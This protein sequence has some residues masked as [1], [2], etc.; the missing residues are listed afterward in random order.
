MCQVEGVEVT[1]VPFRENANALV[2]SVFACKVL[3][4]VFHLLIT[5]TPRITISRVAAS[6]MHGGIA[7]L[8]NRL[9]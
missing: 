5:C 3:K 9:W 4:S 1:F 6:Y 2:C 7:I 8:R